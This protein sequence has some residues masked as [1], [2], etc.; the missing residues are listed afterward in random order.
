VGRWSCTATMIL[1]VTTSLAEPAGD[2]GGEL[3]FRTG[4][5]EPPCPC[6]R[7]AVSRKAM[8]TANLPDL[9]PRPCASRLREFGRLGA[10]SSATR[11]SFPADRPPAVTGSD[12]RASRIIADALVR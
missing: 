2:F 11:S 8:S 6:S 4:L 1:R 12:P 9:K 7:K 3:V 10:A 5:G